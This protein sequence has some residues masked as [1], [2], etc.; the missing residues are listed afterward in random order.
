M[1]QHCRVSGTIPRAQG[2]TSIPAGAKPS[3][4]PAG[5]GVTPPCPLPRPQQGRHRAVLEQPL[6]SLSSLR[7]SRNH[8]SWKRSSRPSMNIHESPTAAGRGNSASEPLGEELLVSGTG[9][10]G[11]N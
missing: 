10:P 6:T 7:P 2:A 8:L 1:G 9:I 5:T 3:P 4:S 11:W